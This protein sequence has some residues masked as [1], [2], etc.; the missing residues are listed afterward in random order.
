MPIQTRNEML[1]TG[2]RSA[3]GIKVFG[4]DLAEI[5]RTAIAIENAV[6]DVPGTRSAFA[7]RLTGGRFLDFDIDR[8]AA[9][10]Y[11]LTVGD[12][13]DVIEAAIGGAAI[14]QTVEGR[15][16]YTVALR[17][18]RELRDQP[19]AL[20]AVLVPTPTGAQVPIGQVAR[21]T[22]RNGPPMI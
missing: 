13:E 12:I 4:P 22:F 7:D 15:E 21:L 14:T 10:R 16:R 17:Y 20:A 6:K 1:A 11:G 18:A 8:A 3:V 9:A 19:D 5:E 2:V